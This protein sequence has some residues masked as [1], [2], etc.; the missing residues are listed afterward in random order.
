MVLGLAM[1]DDGQSSQ[2]AYDAEIHP[3]SD[4]ESADLTRLQDGSDSGIPVMMIVPPCADGTCDLS[5]ILNLTPE[6]MSNQI[7]FFLT[8]GKGSSYEE[9]NSSIH[10]Y[11]TVANSQT[12]GWESWDTLYSADGLYIGQSLTLGLAEHNY[13]EEGSLTINIRVW[14]DQAG[15][16]GSVVLAVY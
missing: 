8:L 4:L 6:R 10:T 1:A 16:R 2:V 15:Q 11:I 7:T 9:D 13:I 14:N 3:D 5:L 12:D